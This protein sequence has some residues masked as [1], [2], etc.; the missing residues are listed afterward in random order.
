M[1]TKYTLIVQPIISKARSDGSNQKVKGA[2]LHRLRLQ[3][4]EFNLV[5]D[6]LGSLRVRYWD[7]FIH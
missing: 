5:Y 7:I 2:V 4:N 1:K 3:Y 6:A